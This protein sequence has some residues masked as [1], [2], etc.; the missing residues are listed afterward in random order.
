MRDLNHFL[1]SGGIIFTIPLSFQFFFFDAGQQPK[2][3][4]R[5]R[6]PRCHKRRRL[7]ARAQ[8]HPQDGGGK[9]VEQG[10][11][12]NLKDA[13][14]ET[15]TSGALGGALPVA[16][17]LL[18]EG[19]KKLGVSALKSSLKASKAIR[20]A[21]GGDERLAKSYEKALDEGIVTPFGGLAKAEE[22]IN[23]GE[24]I[25]FVLQKHWQ[26]KL[27]TLSFYQM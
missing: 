7:V 5:K 6:K 17:K 1:V 9:N 23:D 11:N 18:G 26:Q 10:K 24:L 27:K 25:I 15:V 14:L 4:C 20:N 3:P 12:V 21:P 16:G 8:K 19:A 13:A 22:K 2:L